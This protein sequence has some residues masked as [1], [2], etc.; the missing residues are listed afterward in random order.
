MLRRSLILLLACLLLGLAFTVGYSL[1][2]VRGPEDLLADARQLLED[3][4]AIGAARLLDQT[5]SAPSLRNAPGLRREIWRLRLAANRKADL[6]QRALEDLENLIQDGDTDPSFLLDRIYYLARLGDGERARRY[7]QE[8]TAA[9]PDHA[10]G[11]EL[12]GE[13]CKVAY[14]EPLRTLSKRIRSELGASEQQEGIAAFLELVYRPDGDP[15]LE[16]ARAALEGLYAR[17]PRLKQAW[18]ELQE[19]IR[20][21]RDQ[22]QVAVGMFQRA[23]EV[24]GGDRKPQTNY[25]AA[26]L[27]G[28]VFA[29]QQA[30]RA[31]DL[32]A[33]CEIYLSRF[34]HAYVV[35]AAIAEANANYHDGLYEAAVHAVER[36]LPPAAAK[37]KL[38]SRTLGPQMRAL[39]VVKCLAL[40]RLGR[41]EGLAEMAT[42][43]SP[44][45]ETRPNLVAL[46]GLAWGLFHV[47]RGTKENV[48]QL[49]LWIADVMMR[50]AAPQDG[51]DPLDLLMPL[52]VER[53][54]AENKPTAEI[55]AALDRWTEAR[56][57]DFEPARV[58]AE[59]QIRFGQDAAAMAT[60]T[61]W[62]QQKPEDESALRLL[63]KASDLAYRASQQDGASLLAQCLQ[64]NT[65]RPDSPP[66]PVCYLLCGEAALE[67]QRPYIARTCARLAADRY[68][69]STW[70]F[71]LEA[72]A[73]V[74]QGD[75]D[76]A[77]VVLDRLLTAHPDC[78]EAVELAFE[79]RTR[80]GLPVRDLLAAA[81]RALP[82]SPLVLSAMLRAAIEDDSPGS[83]PLARRAVSLPDAKKDLLALAAH[84]IARSG[85]PLH[86]FTVLQRAHA[87]PSR[88]TPRTAKDVLAATVACLEAAAPGTPDRDLLPAAK[89][90]LSGLTWT[91]PEAGR[92]FVEAARKL[93]RADRHETA[94][95]MLAQATAL[96]DAIEVR[97]GSVH[98]LAGELALELGR[99]ESARSH[100]TAAVAFEDGRE[101]AERLARLAFLAGEPGR[102]AA[103][104]AMAASP[105][106]PA[107]A[108]LLGNAD[109]APIARARITTEPGDL[110]AELVRTLAATQPERG[111]FGLELH[112]AARSVLQD[113]LQAATRCE[114]PGLAESALPTTTSLLAQVPDSSAIQLLHARVLLASGAAKEA[115]ELHARCF[116]AGC[117]SSVLYAEVVRAMANEAYVAPTAVLAE[118]R[119]QAAKNPQSLPPSAL[120]AVAFAAADDA[121][122]QGLNDIAMKVRSETWRAFPGPSRATVAN[123]LQLLQADLV[124]DAFELLGK[125]AASGEEATRPLARRELYRLAAARYADLPGP[126]RTLL[127][128]SAKKDLDSGTEVGAALAFLLAD[129]AALQNRPAAELENVLRAGVT[130]VCHG[131]GDWHTAA[132][133]LLAFEGAVG[134]RRALQFVESILA[135]YP[136]MPRLWLERA[137]LACGVREPDEALADLRRF[138]A[139]VVDPPFLV[140]ATV[141]AA[142]HRRVTADDITAFENL[143]PEA[144]STQRA[145]FAA[146]LLAL[147]RGDG[148]K[149]EEAFAAADDQGAFG[150]FARALANLMTADKDGR[151][152]SKQ[153]FATLA[154]RYPK[155][156]FARNAGSF[157]RQLGPN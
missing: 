6:P 64:R 12:A 3:G 105:E 41:S 126:T 88:P 90:A 134:P 87:E 152:R 4:D 93:A 123:G 45:H 107:L 104:L 108:M 100:W 106:D 150:L 52:Y 85:D 43:I 10:R 149:A 94:A 67:Q 11:L 128:Q 110:V 62:L 151:E 139:L 133:A 132:R 54:V 72:R 17:E 95:W 42:V 63:A 7:A 135:Q 14:T 75:L 131:E 38:D 66:S 27:N 153:L 39:V 98:A 35:E 84:A 29:L 24:V 76:A 2:P 112:A 82:D 121:E 155:S 89:A 124:A 114:E 78:G 53:A 130:A 65:D 61:A 33:Q 119:D 86:A 23:L 34:T 129:P 32:T 138:T 55:F 147:R 81:V 146:G 122:R 49:L 47:L 125:L 113:V 13:A 50:D 144:R 145:R 92:A 9:N 154:E 143:P 140:E 15:G 101:V 60:A 48:A 102:A 120:A 46:P 148:Q 44:L 116:E 73:E 79:T 37:A 83:L 97:D 18:P 69:W 71:L 22:V 77:T 115:A 156:S 25:F 68:P 56:P 16:I 70:P 137:R 74:L 111:A 21:V 91:G 26:A 80:A 99:P 51:E 20:G 40:Y 58:R 157:V 19:R 5:S 28:V 136:T 127:T 36:V 57:G 142:T 118:L 141:L 59:L 8:F 109:A 30:N 117:R 96:G 1:L 103:A 31:D